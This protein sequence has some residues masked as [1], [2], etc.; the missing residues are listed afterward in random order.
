VVTFIWLEVSTLLD[1]FMGSDSIGGFF[2]GQ[3][4]ELVMRFTVESLQNTIAALIW[5]AWVMSW[6]PL[7]GFVALAAMYVLFTYVLNKPLEQWFF[8]DDL[9]AAPDPAPP[10]ND[11][12]EQ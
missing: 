5:P 8:H 7:W 12:E 6:P 11:T 4:L 1:E 10:T 3:L 2:S 9:P